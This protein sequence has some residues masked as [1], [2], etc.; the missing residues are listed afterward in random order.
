MTF[1]PLRKRYIRLDGSFPGAHRRDR[2]VH[3]RDDGQ[4]TVTTT[5]SVI[6]SHE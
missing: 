2:G 3:E 6:A 1:R 5:E 4:R